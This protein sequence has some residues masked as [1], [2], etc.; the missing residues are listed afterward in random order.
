MAQINLAGFGYNEYEAVAANKTLDEGDAGVVQN[1]TATC[2]VTLPATVAGTAYIIRVGAPG[3]TVTVAPAAA[4]KIMGNGF[5]S[6]DNKALIFTTQPAGS[7]V[8]LHADGA[9]GYFVARV[10]G[11]ATRAA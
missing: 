9:N 10:N 5:T 4:D 2:T 8:A 1:V 7:Y 11:T 3:I 6:A